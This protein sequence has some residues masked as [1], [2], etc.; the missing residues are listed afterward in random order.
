MN[1]TILAFSLSLFL[2]LLVGSL[3]A[4]LWWQQTIRVQAVA[5]SAMG[6]EALKEGDYR[7]SIEMFNKAVAYAPKSYLPRMGIA[8]AYDKLGQPQFAIQEYQ[9]AVELTDSRDRSEQLDKVIALTRIGDILFRETKFGKAISYYLNASRL[10]PAWPDAYKGLGLSYYHMGQ[11]EEAARNFREY[12]RV[13]IR[14]TRSEQKQAI[15]DL[16]KKI[17]TQSK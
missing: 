1:K 6:Q 2:G 15:G 17:E 12:I 16:L 7:K 13:E 9:L 8:E 5:A 4:T 14:Q 11:L 3:A 10:E